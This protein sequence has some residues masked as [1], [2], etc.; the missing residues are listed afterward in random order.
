MFAYSGCASV[1]SAST[2]TLSAATTRGRSSS[3]EVTSAA[4]KLTCA[5]MRATLKRSS[6]RMPALF[7]APTRSPRARP[8]GGNNQPAMCRRPKWLVYGS[9]IANLVVQNRGS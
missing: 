5:R 9:F 6:K 1:V 7:A 2:S 3:A 8:L 4:G